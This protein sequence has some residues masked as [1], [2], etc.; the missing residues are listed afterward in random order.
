MTGPAASTV[1]SFPGAKLLARLVRRFATSPWGASAEMA[2]RL[3]YMA[4]GTV[5]LS[6]GVIGLLA[7]V[8]LTPHTQGALGALEAWAHFRP[9]VVLLWVTGIGLWGFAGW[10]AL[11][12]LFDAERQGWSLKGLGNRA[13]Q[14]LSGLIY[15]ATAASVFD[16][17]D[18]LHDIRH[19]GEQAKTREQVAEVLSWPFGPH[20]IMALGVFII[21][22]GLGNAIRAC[23]DNFGATLKCDPGLAVWARRLARVGYFGR[24]VAML[25]VGFFML[26]AGWDARAEEARGVGAA[27]WALHSQILGDLMLTLVALGLMA[28][29]VFAFMEAWYRPIRPEAAF[30][31]LL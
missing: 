9:G 16:L 26:I 1:G 20:L 31:D 25:P 4:R 5:Y 13:G 3:G 14:A 21:G 12:S 6:I 15:G 11:Q 2:A 23:V 30:S 29:G 24:G 22:C 10:R 8:G 17:I 19:Q 18:A 27:L 28:F 7:V